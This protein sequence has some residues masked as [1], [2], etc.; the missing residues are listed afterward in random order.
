MK[1]IINIILW[2]AVLQI[3]RFGFKSLVF[4]FI[5][6]NFIS[7]VIV[8]SIYMIIIIILSIITIKKKG[9]ELN[10]FPK[11]FNWKYI[12]ISVILLVIIFTTAI[13]TGSNS[14][15]HILSLLYG[16]VITVIFEEIIF[17]G[18]VY[19]IVSTIKNDLIAY[20]ISSILFGIWHLGYIDTVIWR[21][22]IISP[23]ANILNI[24]NVNIKMLK[25][26]NMKM[27][28]YLM[29]IYFLVGSF[30]IH[31]LFYMKVQ[32]F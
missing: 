8:S 15:Y 21:V 2:L 28:N 6:K 12:M 31:P 7:D 30:H 24:V 14:V 11:S 23:N 3:A 20:I 27:H 4:L 16:S 26:S 13:I 17:R 22:S 19:K 29:I 5:D 18:Y 1:K 9:I 25:N 10:I 32:Q